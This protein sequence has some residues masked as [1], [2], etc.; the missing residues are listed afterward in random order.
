MVSGGLCNITTDAY[1]TSKSHL[2]AIH[3][4]LISMFVNICFAVY[5]KFM[6]FF[7]WQIIQSTANIAENISH[8]SSIIIHRHFYLQMRYF[9]H[10]NKQFDDNIY[11]LVYQFFNAK[12]LNF[13]ILIRRKMLNCEYWASP[14]NHFKALTLSNRMFRIAEQ[15]QTNVAFAYHLLITMSV[16][17]CHS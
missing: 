9:S 1:L 13:I 5:T 7:K 16:P 6:V 3:L 11:W 10:L 17:K 14:Q 4:L 12:F 15:K 8:K 2:A